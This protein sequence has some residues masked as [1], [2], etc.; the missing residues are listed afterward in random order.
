MRI[1]SE[2]VYSRKQFVTDVQKACAAKVNGIPGDETISKTVTVSEKINC[3]HA[4]VVPLQKR[5]YAL[6]YTD[7]G[8][9]DGVA[10][11]LFTKAVRKLQNNIGAIV[12]GEVTA[13]CKTWR[14]LLGKK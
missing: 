6:G 10:G 9:A 5:L 14:Y 3:T 7:V 13:G 8:E 12:D 11:P 4:V 1:Q 2:S